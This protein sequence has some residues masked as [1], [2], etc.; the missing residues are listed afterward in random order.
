MP[1]SLGVQQAIP[2]R[3]VEVH[4]TMLAQGQNGQ[5]THSQTASVFKRRVTAEGLLTV[6]FY[7]LFSLPQ[8]KWHLFQRTFPS[9]TAR[10]EG[11]VLEALSVLCLLL[12][13][14][15]LC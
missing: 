3:S 10:T 1:Q 15:P 11:V 7:M 4:P 6:L 12:H 8:L 2:P 5:T 9:L 13:W 14:L